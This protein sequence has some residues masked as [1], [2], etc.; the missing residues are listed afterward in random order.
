L[1]EHAA[2]VLAA[3]RKTLINKQQEEHAIIAM[4]KAFTHS[5]RLTILSYLW[6]NPHTTSESIVTATHISRPAVRRHLTVLQ[7]TGFVVGNDEN[8]N[9]I[10]KKATNPL[11]KTLLS[12]ITPALVHRN[13]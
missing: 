9:L 3:L 8:W 7:E 12:A 13:N 2:L 11:V 5:R 6:N 4:L 1:V 10:R